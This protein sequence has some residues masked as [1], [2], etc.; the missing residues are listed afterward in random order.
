[1]SLTKAFALLP[2]LMIVGGV[3]SAKS[4]SIEQSRVEAVVAD[5][6]VALGL[7]YEDGRSR[8]PK[9]QGNVS[10]NMD[11]NEDGHVTDAKSGKGT[12]LADKDAVTCVLGV[13][14]TLDFGTQDNAQT[15]HYTLRFFEEPPKAD[16]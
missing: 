12:T 16:K 15:V 7:C 5:R 8:N 2:F 14:K 11:V 6:S 10:V 3:A 13:M 1:M 9:L 4:T